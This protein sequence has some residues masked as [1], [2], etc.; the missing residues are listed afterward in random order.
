M[1]VLDL[2]MVHKD[3]TPSVSALVLNSSWKE[4]SSSFMPS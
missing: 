2:K 3:S 4:L 1:K